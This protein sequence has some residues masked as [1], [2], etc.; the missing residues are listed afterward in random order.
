MLSPDTDTPNMRD[1]TCETLSAE[2]IA[3][4]IERLI[5]FWRAC[6][7]VE[8]WELRRF[9]RTDGGIPVNNNHRARRLENATSRGRGP[10]RTPAI[11]GGTHFGTS[12]RL[13]D[14]DYLHPLVGATTHSMH[15]PSASFGEGKNAAKV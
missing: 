12:V 7:L 4:E 15:Q 1:E 5:L 2:E 9:T 8:Q 13:D 10:I 3:E 6:D 11:D 14:P